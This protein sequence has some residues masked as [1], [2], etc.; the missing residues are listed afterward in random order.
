MATGLLTFFQ[1]VDDPLLL[2]LAARHGIE[3]TGDPDVPVYDWLDTAIA[4]SAAETRAALSALRDQANRLVRPDLIHHLHGALQKSDKV[5]PPPLKSSVARV[6]WLSLNAPDVIKAAESQID[7]ARWQ[8]KEDQWSGFLLPE[9]ASHPA[10]F[11]TDANKEA[12]KPIFQNRDGTGEAVI[13]EE[14]ERPSTVRGET[15][16]QLTIYR[17]GPTESIGTIKNSQLSTVPITPY[18]EAHVLIDLAARLFDISSERGGKAFLREIATVF[19]GA[20]AI[21]IETL[22]P[23]LPRKI[24]LDRLKTRH[25]FPFPETDRIE[26]VQLIEVGFYDFQGAFIRV[27][28]KDSDYEDMW[29]WADTNG[30]LSSSGALRASFITDVAIEF[31]LSPTGRQRAAKAKTVRLSAVTNGFTTPGLSTELRERVDRL[32][33]GWGLMAAP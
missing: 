5:T 32:C 10:S 25:E 19:L 18:K 3:P 9:D 28:L 29:S 17:D 26:G 1:R 20:M 8:G 16:L 11:D 7:H 2:D 15:A 13:I 14:F 31:S 27:K 21:D 33:V 22:T 24:T 23:A 12:L 6:V 4:A 30:Y